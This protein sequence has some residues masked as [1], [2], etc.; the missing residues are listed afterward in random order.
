MAFDSVVRPVAYLDE[1]GRPTGFA[2]D[3]VGAIARE[4]GFQVEYVTGAKERLWSEFA[5]GRVDLVASLVFTEER[6]KTMDFAL[7]YLVLEG[8]MFGRRDGGRL[9]T[10]DDL[11]GRRVAVT[12]GAVTHDYLRAHPEWK[13]E[14][15]P[16]DSTEAALRLVNEGGCDAA[17]NVALVAEKLVRERGFERVVREDVALPGLLYKYHMAVKKGDAALLR[18]VNEAQWVLHE[19]GEFA[20]LHEKWIGPL[21]VRDLDLRELRPYLWPLAVVLV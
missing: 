9:R 20:R 4:A 12:R 19:R 7:H 6:T 3:Y 17:I 21:K 10:L 16:V 14:I 8:A 5:D 1:Q 11:A 18:R 13:V 15:V 2:A